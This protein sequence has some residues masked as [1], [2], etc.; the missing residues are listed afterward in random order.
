MSV[1]KDSK[2]KQAANGIHELTEHLADTAF[3]NRDMA[4]TT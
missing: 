4:P 2:T 3:H 1:V